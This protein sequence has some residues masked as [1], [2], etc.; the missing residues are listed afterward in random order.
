MAT[1]SF[2]QGSQRLWVPRRRRRVRI[3]DRHGVVVVGASSCA[4]PAQTVGGVAD[5]AADLS[6]H[7]PDLGGEVGDGN[8]AGSDDLA[9]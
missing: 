5:G 1:Y 6:A 4:K 2:T 7:V 3:S 8:A 9:S